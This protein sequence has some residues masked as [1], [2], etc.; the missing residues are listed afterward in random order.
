MVSRESC[1]E[2]DEASA[3]GDIGQGSHHLERQRH[4]HHDHHYDYDHP[5][6]DHNDHNDHNDHDNHDDCFINY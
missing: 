2:Q 1:T 3:Y 4:L 6:H 5:D